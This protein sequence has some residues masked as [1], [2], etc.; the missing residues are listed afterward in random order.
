MSQ[1]FPNSFTPCT[2]SIYIE[3]AETVNNSTTQ[4]KS[5]TIAFRPIIPKVLTKNVL[6]ATNENLQNMIHSNT[7]FFLSATDQQDYSASFNHLS[8]TYRSLSS[9]DSNDLPM[10]DNDIP[11]HSLFFSVT[12]S[13]YRRQI[14]APSYMYSERF[15]VC[16]TVPILEYLNETLKLID[17]R[18]VKYLDKVA[19]V[20]YDS[21]NRTQLYSSSS[22]FPTRHFPYTYFGDILILC[23]IKLFRDN[24]ELLGRFNERLSAITKSTYL[25]VQQL[26]A[27]KLL[28]LE[29]DEYERNSHRY[30]TRVDANAAAL[31]LLCLS[32]DDEIEA[33]KLCT[34]CA[35]K[36]SQESLSIK[37]L[38]AQIPLLVTSLEVLS[39]IAEKHKSLAIYTVRALCDFL[40]EPSPVLYKLYR[41]TSLK[42]DG[43]ER[44]FFFNEQA[45]SSKEY[46]VFQIFE[47]LRDA[48]IEGLCKSLFIRLDSDPKCVE[49]LLVQ[50]SARLASGH[51]NDNSHWVFNI[52]LLDAAALKRRSSIRDGV[53]KEK[54]ESLLQTS[55]VCHNTILTLGHMAITL[56]DVQHTQQSILARFQQRLGDPPSPL[57][58]LIINQIGC[59]LISSLPQT[60]YEEILGLFT[61]IIIDSTYS[62]YDNT[63]KNTTTGRRTTKYKQASN[64][65]INALANVA[66]NIQG[67]LE[68]MN[69][70][71]SIL[72][73]FVQLGLR[74]K[75]ASEKSTKNALKASNT[76]GSL[77]VLIPVIAIVMRRISVIVEPSERV[78]RLFQHFWFYC[79]LFGFADSE[80]GLWPSEWHDCVRLIAT[81]SPTLVAQ[82]GPYVP[83]KSAMPL[84]P[85]QIAKEDNNE[86]KSQ[87]N[88]IFSAYP[89][90][91]PFIDRF[92][93]EQS[94][95]TLSVYYLETFRVCHSLAP[96]AFQCIFSYLEDAGLLKDKYGLWTLM[97]AVGR[98]SFEIYVDEMK[99]M[100]KSP[101]R[102]KNLE[103]QCQFFMVKRTHVRA[104]VREEAKLYLY[105]LLSKNAFPHLFCNSVVIETLMNII[106]I[107][108]YSLNEDNLHKVTAHHRVPNTNYTIQFVDTHEKRLELYNALV[109]F[110]RTFIEQALM[111]SPTLL[112]SCIQ[113]YM[114]KLE[115]GKK[116]SNAARQHKGL[117]VMWEYLSTYSKA[118]DANTT[119]GPTK[120]YYRIDFAD[121]MVSLGER[122][123]AVGFVEGLDRNEYRT[124][125]TEVKGQMEAAIFNRLNSLDKYKSLQQRRRRMSIVAPISDKGSALDFEERIAIFDS[126]FRNA[127][128]K[129]TAILVHNVDDS[130]E[131]EHELRF[132]AIGGA[133]NGTPSQKENAL[134]REMVHAMTWLPVKMFT[135]TVMEGA[136]E[137]WC[138]AIIGRPELEL[139]IVEEIYKAW[140]KIISDRHGLYSIDRPEPSPLAPS[141]K[142][143]LKPK[144]PSVN[145]HRIFLKFIEERVFLCMHKADIEMEMLVDLLHKSLSLILENPR[146]PM[147]KHIGAVGLRFRFVY[148][149]L[150][151]V[152]SDYLADG[153]SKFLL[154]EKIYHTAFDYFTV[155]HHCPTQTHNELRSDIR[156]LIRF[157]S[158][159]HGEK[160]F[161]SDSPAATDGNSPL[162]NGLNN[163]AIDAVSLYGTGKNG[164]TSG[165]INAL[166]SGSAAP[167]GLGAQSTLSRKSGTSAK[168]TDKSNDARILSR[169]LLKKRNLLL[170]L[171]A[172]EIERLETFHNPLGR[173]ELQFD[174]DT[175]STYTN[176]KLYDMNGISNKAWQEYG[177]LAWLISPDLAVSLYYTIPK[178]SLRLEIQRLVKSCPLQV[179][180]IPEALI[181]FTQTSDNDRQCEFASRMLYT[182]K[183]EA[184]ILYI[185]QLV[186]AVRYDE[187]GF[188]RCLIL[189]LSK[190]SNLL[191]HQLI[192]NI[193]T[194]TYKNE[195][196]PD[197]EMQ[198]KL[199]P[200]ARQIELD[201]TTDARNFY[202]RVF[203]FSDRLT[204]VSETIK[205][206][207][208]GNA[209][210]EACL[211][212]LR[213][214][215]SEVP[216]GVYL[217][218]N[219]EA[220]VI[221]LLP[222]SGA[223]MQSAAKAPY[224]ATFRVQTV[225]IEQVERCADPDYELMQDFSN[226]YSQMAI[227]KVGDDVR[228]DILALQLMRLF[229]NIFEQE[230]LE[231]Y[232]YTYRVIATSPGCGVIECVPNSRSREDIGRNTEVGLFEYFR[233]VYGK[234]DSIKFQKARRNFVMS[235]AAYSI[236][237]FMLQIKDRHNGNIMIDDDGHIVHIDFGFMFE[238]SPGGNMRFE[239]DIKLTAE[240]I[241]IM[242]D[243]TAPAFQW[244]KE[245]CIKGY[246]AL[247]RYRHHFVTLVALM[248]DTGLPCFR[249][250]T[251]EQLNARL[252]PDASEAEAGR[253]MHEMADPVYLALLGSA[254]YFRTCTPPNYRLTIQCLQAILTIRLPTLIEAKVH[255]FLGRLYT[256]H[257]T[258]FD[259]ASMHLDKACHLAQM[260]DDIKLESLCL[261]AKIYLNQNQFA[262]SITLLQQAYDLSA[263][264][265]YWHCRIIF[266]IISIY[267]SQEDYN[268]SIYYADRGIEFS[269]RMNALFGQVLF[270][271][272]KAMIRLSMKDYMDAQNLLKP[273]L[274]R[275][276]S[277]Q[278]NFTHI[279][280][281]RIFYLVL[282]ISCSCFG[283]G[284]IKSSKTALMQ[285]QQSI[286]NLASRPEEEA[287]LIGNPLEQFTWL[288]R[289]H[290]NVLVYLL[291]V[292]HSM[293][294]G[295]LEKALKYADKAQ[296]QIEQIK[297]MDHSPFLMAVEMLF[298]EC[299]IQSHLIFGNKSVAIKEIN[300]LCRLHTASNSINNSNAIQRT[301]TI[302]ALLGLYA[303]SLNFNEAAEAQFASALRTRFS[304]DKEFRFFVFAN[305][306]M[307][308]LRTSKI[309][310]L[311]P[312]L[313]QINID[314][315]TTQ[316]AILHA[317]GNLLNGL[318]N[319]TQSRI[320]EAKELFRRAANLASNEDLNKILTN[321][322]II[323]G[324]MFFRMHTYQESANMLQSATTIS[325]SIPDYT[326]QL[327]TMSLLRD[328]YHVCND[329]RLAETNDR[330]IQLNDNL[331]K[332]YQS[333]VALAEHRHLLTWTDGA[334]PMIN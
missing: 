257:T 1:L 38:A 231:L 237:L 149:A 258:N 93:F 204:K 287:Y 133:P 280:T 148:L 193:R 203:T 220:I 327:N 274:D 118:A 143:E 158:L 117:H 87:L 121:Y 234:D 329:P 81:K 321:T 225:G 273:C 196:T 8:S 82:N 324:H 111:M 242:G 293:L 83:L 97:T 185:P 310:N 161:C 134:D 206:Y 224:R 89:T 49:A 215:G 269:A 214:I 217:P 114:L 116:I 44:A 330:V 178:E 65:V 77:G 91:K 328:L 313:Q 317:I 22:K 9:V 198:A 60:T 74:A 66:A 153:V 253:Y 263:Q 230:G 228:Q 46:R 105:S 164:G 163:E 102:N 199:E 309:A 103:V 120:L 333:A 85:E 223:P 200:I 296:A 144:P 119:T 95:Y 181:I 147:T 159:V 86:L 254:E 42:I 20:E 76:A 130:E 13:T 314:L 10:F 176:W 115:Q 84:K 292:F 107:L 96:S 302:H 3:Q 14:N 177:R 62:T 326:A 227:F 129:L 64:A 190:K 55:L 189:A 131:N 4:V 100:P 266:Q 249:G 52:V 243:L 332:D 288:S 299:R 250:H 229:Q 286:Q 210:K 311:I 72:E 132:T 307:V 213:S 320:H 316:S 186:Q 112:K 301:L 79:V 138:W 141:E 75:D 48:A 70:L 295:R 306:I 67:S 284:Q 222:E 122:C 308:Y 281:M 255:L 17:N 221:S 172:Y 197:N 156:T 106:N 232:L 69:L 183:S 167:P 239:P 56:K 241:L 73:L 267:H 137:C 240:M 28:D 19:V 169:D 297:S 50:L 247:R 160:K 271:L 282:H 47:K 29:N 88:S 54:Y 146:A 154:R 184:L 92:G 78:F 304:G 233:H 208:K 298:Y 126:N 23:I 41:H 173:P 21:V 236:A 108:S 182:T 260:P 98:K 319:L 175:Q 39:R 109:D 80:R 238:S 235:M 157:F 27:L 305:L 59:M 216:P 37:L 268:T 40:T 6:S 244:F 261:L 265:P 125:I 259:M 256:Q 90:A 142:Q 16:L 275:I 187:M 151:L 99:K 212:A 285:L 277:L 246:L 71:T 283:L 272:T 323:L 291:T 252:K 195:D 150:Y 5:P 188:V 191:A 290:L 11:V 334:C 278:G 155:D 31:E 26:I 180:H 276:N 30:R 34:K 135:T 101:E 45:K 12:G 312:I 43:Q 207:P 15:R 94:A 168:N 139:L 262:S 33:E 179:R 270:Q 205:V 36:F 202:E 35:E 300:I 123:S 171:L 104:E 2:Q 18:V 63:N 194:N 315:N 264:Q 136:I 218:S 170:T 318:Q 32:C 294:S 201:F 140:E 192:W 211:Q 58:I 251:L 127:L 25:F 113:Q 289:D 7:N 245:L 110:G 279:E 53:N 124:A 68:L 174:Q 248:L 165:W 61:D 226:Q 145:P 128:F 325:Q 331:Q 166:A 57:D 162:S 209:R 303:T 51:V 322:F 219:P 152:Q 24:L